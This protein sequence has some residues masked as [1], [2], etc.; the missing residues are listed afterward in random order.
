MRASRR[1][2]LRSCS[3]RAEA[4]GTPR[5]ISG[6]AAAPES[7]GTVAP[8]GSSRLVL[9]VGLGPAG[10]PPATSQREHVTNL[11]TRS[12]VARVPAGRGALQL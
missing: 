9:D 10:S 1:A 3:R 8:M 6:S 2:F 4:P 12:Y 5:A 11:V 7:S